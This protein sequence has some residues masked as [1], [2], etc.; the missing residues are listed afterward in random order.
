MH[1]M[2]AQNFAIRPLTA[3]VH[4]HPDKDANSQSYCNSNKWALFGFI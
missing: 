3:T 4:C 2:G 1:V